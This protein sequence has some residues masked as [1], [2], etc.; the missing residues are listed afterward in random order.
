MSQNGWKWDVDLEALV[1]KH[2]HLETKDG[3]RREGRITAVHTKTFTLDGVKLD[4]PESVELNGDPLDLI[5]LDK[6][7]T[8]DVLRVGESK[9]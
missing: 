4:I 1:G 5:P 2:A 9:G 3:T 6:L 8:L 7:Q